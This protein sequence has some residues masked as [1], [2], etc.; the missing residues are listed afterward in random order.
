M[1]RPSR[2]VI[3]ADDLTGAADTGVQ[4]RR[5]GISARV[6]LEA[7]PPEDHGATVYDVDSRALGSAEAAARLMALCPILGDAAAGPLYKKVDSTV[8]GNVGAESE[9][10]LRALGRRVAMIAPAFPAN[11]RTTRGG[12]QHV[13][14]VPVHRT[15][16]ASDPA[17]PMRHPSIE[18]ALRSQT[19]LPITLLPLDVVRRGPDEIAAALASMDLGLAV[20]DAEQDADLAAIAAAVARLGSSCLP[21]GSAGLAAHLPAAWHLVTTAAEDSPARPF[22]RMTAAL[23]VCGS[24]NPRTLEQAEQLAELLGA[25][26]V[27]ALAEDAAAQAA[28]RLRAGQPVVLSSAGARSLTAAQVAAAIGATFREVVAQARPEALLLTGGD[29][30]RAA[31]GA[32]GAHGVELEAE[33]LP[34][35]P[36]GR[37]RGGTLE[38]TPV[39]TKAGGFG[40]PDALVV[41]LRYLQ[42]ETP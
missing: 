15:A 1:P 26:P 30:A 19:G 36:I 5:A 40:P 20:A 38:G 2:V 4:F 13:D 17:H 7:H 39:I 42:E 14:G 18:A 29:T 9:A 34:G 10:L 8:R 3:V 23:F 12:V 21:V 33:L 35:L 16:A 31:L 41:A 37:L 24:L 28:A 27:D 25:A 11:G 32:V 22:G 6:W